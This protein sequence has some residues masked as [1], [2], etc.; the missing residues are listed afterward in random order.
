MT[1]HRLATT[2]QN[3]VANTDA[4]CMPTFAAWVTRAG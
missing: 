3:S 2:W 1:K 4:V